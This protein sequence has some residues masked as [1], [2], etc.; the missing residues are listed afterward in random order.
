VGSGHRL[1][2][3]EGMAL[4]LPAIATRY[5]GI[6]EIIE[7]GKTGILV[8]PRDEHG[9]AQ[10]IER[11]LEDPEFYAQA[12]QNALARFQSRFAATAVAS[13]YLGHYEAV[14]RDRGNNNT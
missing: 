7:D 2:L 12:R 4:G 1:R 6:P 3:I 10:A 5:S 13:A 11:F 14:L 9:L 8:E